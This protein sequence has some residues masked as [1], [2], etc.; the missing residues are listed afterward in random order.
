MIQ[1]ISLIGA[2]CVLGGYVAIQT[3]RVGADNPRYQALNL[4]GSIALAIAAVVMF[5]LGF[6]L[7]NVVWA[8]VSLRA[9]VIGYR[10]SRPREGGM[11]SSDG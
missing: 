11:S 5:N 2:V 1:V 6:I 7:L 8:L 3:Q 4:V 10:R 9:L